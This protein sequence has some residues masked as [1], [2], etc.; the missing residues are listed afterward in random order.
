MGRKLD[1]LL[2]RKFKTSKFKATVNLAVS[3]VTVLKNQRQARL[4]VARSDIIQLLNLDHH[5]NALLRVD[6]VIKE[7]N[8]LD[9][10][11][12]VDGYCHVVLQMV[13]LIEKEK[14]C[15]DELK[16]A[17]SSLLYA[18]PRC[19]EFP[20][21]QEVREIL[22]S[23][24]GKEFARGAIELRSNCGVNTR[25]IQKLSPRQ[26]SLETRMKVLQEI[27]V[28]NGIVLKFEDSSPVVKEVEEEST[29]SVLDDEVVEALSFSESTKGK[30]K[31]RDVEDAAQAA[32]E[33]AA[34]AAAA[35]RAAVELSRSRS[36]GSD[37]PD[38]P[39]SRP[40]KVLGS[41]NEKSKLWMKNEKTLESE[42]EPEQE[43]EIKTP[44]NDSNP[45]VKSMVFDES[46]N[47]IENEQRDYSST[48]QVE[49]KSGNTESGFGDELKI[50]QLD[51]TKRPISVRTRRV[52]GR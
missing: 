37:N 19:G 47:E 52:Y 26:S 18:A 39:N 36:F 28:E 44:K 45:L 6:Q 40:R 21:L 34:Y 41:N 9:V 25:M 23:R 31:Y 22:T 8:M 32:F 7:Q 15:P 35:A 24:Y 33:S 29:Q 10:L 43:G 48:K 30:K 16:E 27:A 14:D 50:Q 2:G 49:F 46:D 4:A 20:E 11:V 12:M 1:A 13:N 5:E 3:R 51:L 17:V 38:S 42:S